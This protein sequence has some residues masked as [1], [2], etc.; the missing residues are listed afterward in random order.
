MSVDL[1]TMGNVAIHLRQ[2]Y[3]GQDVKMLPMPIFNLEWERVVG[4]VF[5]CRCRADIYSSFLP[6]PLSSTSISD[7]ELSLFT[8]TFSLH[9]KLTIGNIYNV[10]NDFGSRRNGTIPMKVMPLRSVQGFS[11]GLPVTT[12]FLKLSPMWRSEKVSCSRFS[13]SGISHAD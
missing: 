7:L 8:F 1:W 12:T 4:V 5:R 13:L 10:S 11:Y 9:V 3:G 6:L 2:G